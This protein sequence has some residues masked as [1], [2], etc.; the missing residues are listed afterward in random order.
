MCL[1]IQQYKTFRQ[2][3]NHKCAIIHSQD[4]NIPDKN[5]NLFSRVKGLPFKL[6]LTFFTPSTIDRS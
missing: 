5:Y 2:K 6:F 4:V 3:L 1:Y